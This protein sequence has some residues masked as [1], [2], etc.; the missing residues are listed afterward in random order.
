MTK[1][2]A[3]DD[4][5]SFKQEQFKSHRADSR[6]DLAAEIGESE[7]RMSAKITL[8]NQETENRMMKA[9]E[10]EIGE[11]KDETKELKATMAT[12]LG[13]VAELRTAQVTAD[14]KHA[15]LEKKNYDRGA[16]QEILNQRTALYVHDI[17]K[18][19]KD[20][21]KDTFTHTVG[22]KTYI[23]DYVECQFSATYNDNEQN[24]KYGPRRGTKSIKIEQISFFKPKGDK[25]TDNNSTLPCIVKFCDPEAARA[26]KREYHIDQFPRNI[27]QSTLR[28]FPEYNILEK[29]IKQ[30]LYILKKNALVASYDL[31]PVVD[32]NTPKLTYSL[33][34]RPANDPTTKEIQPW[35]YGLQTYIGT[36]ASVA[37]V[38]NLYKQL[39]GAAPY[40]MSPDKISKIQANYDKE[41]SEKANRPSTRRNP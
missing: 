8:V 9:L 1:G 19:F 16:H 38:H 26:F 31:R 5:K 4:W 40:N 10:H 21:E 32:P 3:P 28:G 34:I 27:S 7:K 24:G 25:S 17:S 13:E 30:A 36:T 11:L 29:K 12:M 18:I 6:A 2:A 33:S 39:L 35:M 41:I 15:V 23:A 20:L 37:N 22:T 14:K